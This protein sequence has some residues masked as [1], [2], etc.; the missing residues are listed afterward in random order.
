MTP[1]EAAE[2]VKSL[3]DDLAQPM[4]KPDYKEFIER[5]A[6]DIEGWVTAIDEEERLGLR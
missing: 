1:E 4:S 2:K 5:L 6:S 3:I